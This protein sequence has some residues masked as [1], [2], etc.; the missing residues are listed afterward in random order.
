[1]S[2]RLFWAGEATSTDY[3]ATVYGALISGKQAAK[4]ITKL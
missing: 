4:L 3:P 1:M 2:D